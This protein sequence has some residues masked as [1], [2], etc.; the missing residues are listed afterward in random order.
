MDWL[1]SLLLIPFAV[2][3]A[4]GFVTMCCCTSKT[5][6]S[7]CQTGTQRDT[8]E[9]TFSADCEQFLSSE[10]FIITMCNATT[11]LC[12]NDYCDED[13][14]TGA[15]GRALSVTYSCFAGNDWLNVD[16]RRTDDCNLGLRD[17]CARYRHTYSPDPY[18]CSVAGTESLTNISSTGF[19]DGD[20]TGVSITVTPV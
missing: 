2:P 11:C 17:N 5:P 16:V 13:A 10:V 3:M 1:A 8:L 19:C 4:L 15:V 20:C 18:D 7:C 6:C 9:I 12:N 14:A